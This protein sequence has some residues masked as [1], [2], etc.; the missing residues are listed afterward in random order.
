MRKFSTRVGLFVIL[1]GRLWAEEPAL[2][3]TLPVACK[4]IMGFESYE[5]LPGAALTTEDKLLVYYRPLGYKIET[6]QTGGYRAHLVQEAR[7][8]R[9]GEKAVIWSKP[10][11]DF[12]AKKQEPLGPIYLSNTIGMKK[13]KSGD[14]DLDI[15]LHDK[16]A[17]ATVTQ[18][19]RFQVVPIKTEPGDKTKPPPS[20]T[21]GP[22]PDG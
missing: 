15:I 20:K 14:Y 8:R 12:E 16:L 22:A 18:I 17:D 1:A 9:R 3:M 6:T 19:L 21:L 10:I 5:E 4:T 7:V 2:T 13:L 11:L